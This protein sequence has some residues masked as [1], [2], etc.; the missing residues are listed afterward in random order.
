MGT[1]LLPDGWMRPR[2]Y[3]NGVSVSGRQLY[4]AGMIGWDAAQVFH[5]DDIVGQTRQALENVLAVLRA[6]GAGPQHIVRMT[7]YVVDRAEYVAAQAAIGQV[8]REL[9]GH[10]TVAMSAVQVAALIEPKA[11]VEIEVTAVVP[12]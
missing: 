10:Y 9:I 4:V 7:W 8:Y 12:E 6:G 3:A 11:R 5:H 1:P 2:G